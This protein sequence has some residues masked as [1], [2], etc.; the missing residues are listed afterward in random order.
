MGKNLTIIL[1]KKGEFTLV[2]A[3]SSQSY[4]L[5]YTEKNV[6]KFTKMVIVILLDCGIMRNLFLLI[7][8]CTLYIYTFLHLI[9]FFYNLK[10]NC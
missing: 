6:R 2:Y 10:K 3:I 5:K 8:A 9:H 7:N 4:F 1:V